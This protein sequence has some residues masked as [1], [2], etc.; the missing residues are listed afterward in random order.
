M[1]SPQIFVLVTKLDLQPHHSLRFHTILNVAKIFSTISSIL[2]IFPMSKTQLLLLLLLFKLFRKAE[3]VARTKVKKQ[4]KKLSF[5]PLPIHPQYTS[6]CRRFIES[7]LRIR[8]NELST[9]RFRHPASTP[10]NGLNINK[11]CGSAHRLCRAVK[12]VRKK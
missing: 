5:H 3:S 2:S 4:K 11:E 9:S 12:C 1:I 8:L 7:C 6:L 10:R